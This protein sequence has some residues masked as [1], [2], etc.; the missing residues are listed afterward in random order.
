[1][2]CQYTLKTTEKSLLPSHL[3]R[4]LS[5]VPDFKPPQHDLLLT[6]SA[7]RLWE[8]PLDRQ[9]LAEVI[10]PVPVTLQCLAASLAVDLASFFDNF[11]N[12]VQSVEE[13]LVFLVSYV[14]MSFY[15]GLRFFHFRIMKRRSL[16]WLSSNPVNVFVPRNIRVVLGRD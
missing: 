3:V 6:N 5:Y 16:A 2:E 9:N 13:D 4:I 8:V 11:L 7:A 12:F 10:L 15:L 1:M 14:L